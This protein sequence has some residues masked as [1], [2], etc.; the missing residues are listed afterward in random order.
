MKKVIVHGGQAHADEFLA[1]AFA[2]ALSVI[3]T[4][5]KVFRRDPTLEEL[6]DS[7]ALVLDV[8]GQNCPELNNFDHHQRG[9]EEAPECAM[10]LFLAHVAP[11]VHEVL[12]S[13]TKWYGTTTSLDVAGPFALAKENGCEPGLIFGLAGAVHTPIVKLLEKF[14]GDVPVDA[15]T[16]E[17]LQMVGKSH[18]EYAGELVSL[19]ADVSDKATLVVVDGVRGIVYTEDQ[20]SPALGAV[21]AAY[22]NKQQD[23][24]DPIGFS[25]LKDDRGPGLTLYRFDDD[26]RVDFSRLADLGDDVTFAHPGGFIAKTGGSITAPLDALELVKLALVR[27]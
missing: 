24:D 19:K 27:G 8:G 26:S 13:S 6:E 12:S 16:M 23:A 7:D 15:F 5:T 4:S 10:S 11:E 17:L 22:R 21:L 9:R 14:S 1:L 2:L 25:V 18:L 20:K 3:T